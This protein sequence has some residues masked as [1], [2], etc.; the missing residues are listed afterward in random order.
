MDL[1]VSE[2][3]ACPEDT[4]LLLDS[5]EQDVERIKKQR[6]RVCLEVGY[7]KH[8]LIFLIKY[9]LRIRRSHDVSSHHAERAMRYP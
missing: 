2:H 4:Y 3:N 5:L 8:E 1:L 9:Q 7:I 6:P